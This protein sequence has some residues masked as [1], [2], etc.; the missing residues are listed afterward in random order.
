MPPHGPGLYGATHSHDPQYP[1]DNWNLYSML[2]PGTTALNITKPEHAIGIFKPHVLKLSD[3]PLIISDA[4]EEIIVIAKFTSP[5]HIRKLMFIGG[6]DE[7]QHPSSV[8][9]YPNKDDIDFTNVSSYNPAQEFN[10]PLNSTGT[11]EH[12][13]A[14]IQPFSNIMCCTFYF[15]TNNGS[16]ST[17]IKYIGMQGEHTHYRREA[18]NAKYEVLCTGQDIVQPEGQLGAHSSHMH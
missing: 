18:V 10:L 8:K 17:I 5:V 9:I 6:G 15:P 13:I 2:D 3:E 14:H 7:S 11:I 12:T 1:D 4:D 16:D